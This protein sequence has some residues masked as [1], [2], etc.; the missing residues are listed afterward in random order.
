MLREEI[1]SIKA[2]KRQL[3]SF[4]I[5]LGI[6]F[7]ALAGLFFWREISGDIV[8]LGV[9]ILLFLLGL[10][11]PVS[12]HLLYKPW[13]ILALLLGFIMTRVLLVGIY[14]LLFIPIGL[15]MRAFGK[16]SLH[17]KLDPNAKTYWIPKKYDSKSPDRFERYY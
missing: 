2:G 12:L 1:R 16:D 11:A 6:A 7:M 14:V 4:G 3:Q 9:G 5:T 15:L 13:M 17:R 8:I 10:I